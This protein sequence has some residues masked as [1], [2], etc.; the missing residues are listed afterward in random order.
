MAPTRC[1]LYLALRYHNLRP[2]YIH[3]RI[4]ELKND[5]EFRMLLCHVDIEDNTSPLLFLNDLCV[6]NNLILMLAWSEEEAGRYLET[7]KSLD[8]R[9]LSKITGKKESSKH[10]D[11]MEHVLKSARGV[12]KSD[13]HQLLTQFGSFKKIAAASVDE[14]CT[15]PG[16]GEKKVR[17]LYE[18]FHRPFK[19]RRKG[20]EKVQEKEQ[21]DATPKDGK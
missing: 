9:D 18:A 14:L 13:A 6:Q 7:V 4:A 19:K 5:F 16:V 21:D 10:S 20:P 8:G 15:C 3:R 1:A 12:N 2:N 17:R 11:Q